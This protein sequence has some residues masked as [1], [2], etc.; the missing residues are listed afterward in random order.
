MSMS[1][2]NCQC[3]VGFHP[4]EELADHP[5]FVGKLTELLEREETG[6]T[7]PYGKALDIGTHVRLPHPAV[8][9][10]RRPVQPARRLQQPRDVRHPL[11]RTDRRSRRPATV[12]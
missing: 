12:R 7:P 11:H 2:M 10:T 9:P 8:E 6:R 3:R 5:P 1:R 4:W